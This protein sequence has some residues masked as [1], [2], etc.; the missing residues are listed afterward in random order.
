MKIDIKKNIIASTILSL[1]ITAGGL[2]I[3]LLGWLLFKHPLLSIV[4]RG[5]DINEYRGFGITVE[6]IYSNESGAVIRNMYFSFMSL[7]ITFVIVT[8]IVFVIRLI[9]NRRK[10]DNHEK[11]QEEEQIN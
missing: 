2:V 4:I 11:E 8:L 9:I 3:N 7:I 10:G 6:K 5:A 1:C